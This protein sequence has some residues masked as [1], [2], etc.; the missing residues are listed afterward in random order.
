MAKVLRIFFY[1]IDFQYIIAYSR[2]RSFTILYK[3]LRSTSE[4]IFCLSHNNNAVLMIK[5]AQLLFFM[6]A[7]ELNFL[8]FSTAGGY[9]DQYWSHARLYP[10]SYGFHGL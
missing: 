9:K 8:I 7:F 4:W 6:F 1:F 3:V 10:V 5:T 2:I